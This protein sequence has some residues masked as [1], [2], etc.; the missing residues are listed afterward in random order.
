L[1]DAFPQ[2]S[3]GN[4]NQLWQLIAENPLYPV[5]PILGLSGYFWIQSKLNGNVVDILSGST[6]PGASLDA[7]PKQDNDNQLWT[8]TLDPAGSGYFFISSKLNGNVIDILEASTKPGAGLDAYPL[9]GNANQLWKFVPDGSGWGFLESKLNGNVIDILGAS[10]KP[11]A[12]LDAYPRT[13]N[14]N[15]LWMAVGSA[16]PELPPS[17]TWSNLGTGSGT[18]SSGATECSYTLNLTI[19]Q[20]GSCRFWGSYTNRGDVPIITAPPQTFGVS[21]VVLDLKGNGYSFAAGGQVPSAPQQGSTYSWDRTQ[22]S[23]AIAANWNSIATRHYADY[24]YHNQASLADI[25]SEIEAS[26]QGVAQTAQ[27]VAAAVQSIMAIFS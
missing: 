5:I 21:I 3:T 9:T 14:A 11:G 10:T 26:V 6:K 17:L 22:K 2:K 15:Q 20:D 23:T 12:G 16:F 25:L 18:T 8:F 13:G 4:D 19:S 24:G 7:W 27:A 1:L